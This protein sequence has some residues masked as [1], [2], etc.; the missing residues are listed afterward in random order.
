MIACDWSDACSRQAQTTQ[1]TLVPLVKILL[2]RRCPSSKC[3]EL[4]RKTEA[5]VERKRDTTSLIL[6]TPQKRF[7]EG[8]KTRP[9]TVHSRLASSQPK[10]CIVVHDEVQWVNKWLCGEH[11]IQNC[12]R[13]RKDKEAVNH[14]CQQQQCCL[15]RNSTCTAQITIS[16]LSFWTAKFCLESNHRI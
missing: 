14:H 16:P 9:K 5:D 13:R 1:W 10:Y 11:E 7:F 4:W 8:G 2:K 3:D 15:D 12:R 6:H